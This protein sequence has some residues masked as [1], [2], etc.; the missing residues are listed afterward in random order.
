ME[1]ALYLIPA[2][3]GDTPAGQVLPAYNR[4]II[5]QIKYFIVENLRSA[6]RFLKK[7]DRNID[8][9]SLTFYELNEHT[10]KKSIGNYLDPLGA[11][12][13]MGVISE[14]GCP[15]IADPGADIVDLAQR[16]KI[17]VIPLVGP[18]S[19]IMA[20][21]GSGF[22]GQNFAF[23]GYLP[24]KPVDRANRLRQLESRVHKENQTQL[25]I[26]TPY[27]NAKMIESILAVCRPDTRLCIAAGITCPEE[28]IRT[29]TVADWKKTTLPLLDK[30]PAIFLL[31][32]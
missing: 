31:Y 5:V 7:V 12:N 19:I 11:G 9:G 22:N 25:F 30:T 20:V 10:S 4:D 16:K 1:A 21:M 29:Q 17:R 32:K 3:L 24:P 2:T 13:A 26:E 28:Y 6:R 18:S 27:R 14:A 15:A 23:N 8:I